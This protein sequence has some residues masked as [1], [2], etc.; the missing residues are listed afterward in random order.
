MIAGPLVL[1]YPEMGPKCFWFLDIQTAD[2]LWSDFV[3]L[4]T[5]LGGDTGPGPEQALRYSSCGLSQPC[6]AD[7]LRVLD[8]RINLDMGISLRWKWW[9][10]GALRNT[11]LQRKVLPGFLQP[12]VQLICNAGL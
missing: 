8:M 10:I 9:R 2:R 1:G 11:L 3:P 6:T 7:A 12:S 4:W 5:L